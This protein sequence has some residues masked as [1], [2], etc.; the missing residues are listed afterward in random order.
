MVMIIPVFIITN[1]LLILNNKNNIKKEKLE[2]VNV[3]Y[4][5]WNDE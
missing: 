3:L 4:K 2:E 5:G 1:F